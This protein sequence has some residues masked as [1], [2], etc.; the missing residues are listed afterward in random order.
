MI[1]TEE[2]VGIEVYLHQTEAGKRFQGILKHRFSDFIVREVSLQ[3]EVLHLNSI[4]GS[5]LEA[6]YFPKQEETVAP[7]DESISVEERLVQAM[8]TIYSAAVLDASAAEK[9]QESLVKLRAFVRAH[10]AKD[11]TGEKCWIGY[12]S[13]DKAI[14]TALHGAVRAHA[15]FLDSSTHTE[16][17]QT[18]LK[19]VPK[20]GGGGQNK[21]QKRR[22][23]A[24]PSNCPNYLQATLLKENV[25]T[26][27]AVN[28]VSRH[29]HVRPESIGYAGTKDKRGITAQRVTF[30]RKKPSDLTKFNSYPNQPC[31]RIGDFSYT[32][33]ESKLGDSKGNRFEITLRAIQGDTEIIPAACESAKECG[34]INYFGLQRFGRGGSASH[35]IGK[36]ML[37]NQWKECVSLMFAPRSNDYQNMIGAKKKFFEGDYEASLQLLPE[38]MFAERNVLRKLIYQMKATPGAKEDWSGAFNTINRFTRLICVHAL[39]SYLF[40]KAA[41]ER[42]RKFGLQ[43]VVGDLVAVDESVLDQTDDDAVVE[44]NDQESNQKETVE[45]PSQ[46]FQ[47]SEGPTDSVAAGVHVVTEEDVVQNRFTMWDLVLPLVGYESVFPSNEIGNYFHSLLEIDGLSIQTFKNCSQAYRMKGGYRKV[48]QK[49]GNLEWELKQYSDPN[50]DLVQTEITKFKTQQRPRKEIDS[51]NSGTVKNESAIEGEAVVQDK[52]EIAQHQA[53][54]LKFTLPPGTYA[55]MLLREIM[56]QSTEVEY[57]SQMSSTHV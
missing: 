45:E 55:T 24:W 14:R 42:V 27:N 34:F 35:C 9:H 16:D 46:K 31:I 57:M 56:K 36:H 8:E 10:F 18:F 13:S 52:I 50:E 54:T 30:Y 49:P 47:K 39:Q 23:D 26:L 32:N 37:Q 25:D 48:I 7:Q 15:S 38:S 28:V 43:V 2:S 44:S 1:Q 6:Q 53:L 19:V 40:N 5:A 22:F 12:P 29:I 51:E 21:G 17:N 20:S 33:Q 41:S 3:G 11:G 4:D